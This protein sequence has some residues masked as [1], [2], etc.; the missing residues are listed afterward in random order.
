MAALDALIR[1]LEAHGMPTAAR[2]VRRE[3]VESYMAARREHVK[4][5]TLSVEFRAL[6]QFWRWALEEE[7]IDRSPM[8]RMKAPTVPD[9]PV[10]VVSVADFKKLLRDGRGRTFTERRDA[11]I[12]LVL[13][14]TGIRHRRADRPAPRRRGAAR[15]AGLRHRQGRPYPG[16]PLRHQDRRCPR[17]LPPAAA[18]AS[19]RRLR[20]PVARA[21][22]AAH[23]LRRGEHAG[24][25]LRTRRAPACIRTSS[26]TPSR[27][28]SWL[29]AG[30]RATCSASPAGAV[31]RC[32]GAMAPRWPTSGP[33]RRTAARRTACDARSGSSSLGLWGNPAH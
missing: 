26:A 3:H 18:G 15:A 1:H 4:P 28:S 32:C 29:T 19:L 20:R 21:G 16:R 11:A 25:A 27:I 10:P 5:A 31:R 14:D 9:A 6:Q 8:E 12:L 23:V 17:S 7:E 24:P 22:R 30:R 13:F 33:G 2:S